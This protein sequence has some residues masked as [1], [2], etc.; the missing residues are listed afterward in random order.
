[1][2]ST[3]ST[4][5]HDKAYF[6]GRQMLTSLL[7][8]FPK[9]TRHARLNTSCGTKAQSVAK[10]PRIQNREKSRKRKPHYSTKQCT[11]THFV[12]F[13]L[14]TS[15]PSKYVISDPSKHTFW[16]PSYSYT[17]SFDSLDHHCFRL[18][19]FPKFRLPPLR[20]RKLWIPTVCNT[21]VSLRGCKFLI[22]HGIQNFRIP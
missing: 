17:A 9:V 6:G 7:V 16:V 1:M 20:I 2:T 21:N 22:T 14:Y 10:T 4:L 15:N 5:F 13:K 12:P 19:H 11:T 18:P 3:Q 8:R